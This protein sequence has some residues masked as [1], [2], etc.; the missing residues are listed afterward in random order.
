MKTVRRNV[1]HTPIPMRMQLAATPQVQPQADPSK[2]AAALDA[3]VAALGLPP[4]ASPDDV[5]SALDQFFGESEAPQKPPPEDPAQRKAFPGG[6]SPNA[7]GAS[8]L[9]RIEREAIAK[10]G[11]SE[12]AFLAAK[13]RGI[14]R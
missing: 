13:R 14:C 11:I 12:A 4:D 6:G 9:S 10:S 8:K 3:L 1:L 2:V 7:V 5:A